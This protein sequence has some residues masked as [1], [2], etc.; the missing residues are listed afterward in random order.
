[1][2]FYAPH[3]PYDFQPE[4]DRQSYRRFDL[5]CFP[6]TPMHPWQNTGLARCTAMREAKRSY[7][8]LITGVDHNVGR[9]LERLEK[10]RLR[11]NTLVVFTADQG[12]NAGHHGVWGKG[13]GTVPFNMYEESLRV[14]LIWNHPR[15]IRGGPG[16]RPHGLDLRLLPQHPRLP[17]DRAARG[18]PPRGHELRA[19][20]A[21]Q[22]ARLAQ[23][24]LLRV[25][26]RARASAPRT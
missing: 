2:P 4:R 17:R 19:L 13:N 23:P 16:A 6:D 10:L 1:M 11:D 15:R 12:W 24:A 18:P 26:L 5:P 7:S 20:P 3:T 22:E 8:A 21:R 9:V 14:P 25:R